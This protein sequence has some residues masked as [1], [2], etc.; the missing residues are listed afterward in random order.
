MGLRRSPAS[1]RSTASQ[2]TMASRAS[3]M[4]TGTSVWSPS[5]YS[6]YSPCSVGNVAAM[7]SFSC[8][9]SDSDY[10]FSSRGDET[11]PESDTTST[12]DDSADSSQ[13][14]AINESADYLLNCTSATVSKL[15]FGESRLYEF[16][17]MDCDTNS[18]TSS[19]KSLSMHTS[20]NSVLSENISLETSAR[21]TTVDSDA[22]AF[23]EAPLSRRPVTHKTT[24]QR[25]MAKQLKRV[26]KQIRKHGI[27]NLMDTLAVL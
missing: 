22:S 18:S 19:R 12:D 24:K 13:S 14:D 8:Q 25:S 2:W 9:L 4:T 20:D 3:Q 7:L 26:G 21:D 17:D 16:S 1:A 15:M 10:T 23:M 27:H 5:D 11:R 6:V